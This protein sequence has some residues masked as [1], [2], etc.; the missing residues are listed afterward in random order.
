MP[1]MSESG[2]F[3]KTGRWLRWGGAIGVACIVVACLIGWMLYRHIPAWYQPAYVPAEDEQEARDALGEAFTALS[4]GM[5]EGRPFDYVVRQ[6]ALNRWLMA[7]ERI[8][9]ASKRWIPDQIEDPVIVFRQ[10]EV[11]VA[12]T[13]SGPGPR[14]VVNIRSRLEMIDGAPRVRVMSVRCGS[15]P[16]PLAPIK[17]QLA[18]LERDRADRGRSLLPDGTSIVAA[19]EGAPLPR[20]LPWSQPKGEFRIEALELLPG[21]LRVRLRPVERSPSR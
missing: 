18:R 19:T 20:D 9:P 3:V 12:G 11:V 10:D 5:G 17:E 8:W 16:V 13:W 14:T 1:D 7:R 2:R 4:R 15:L 6:E 21:E